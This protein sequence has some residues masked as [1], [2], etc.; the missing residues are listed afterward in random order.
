M[1]P[2][3]NGKAPTQLSA[4]FRQL[5]PNFG[6]GGKKYR[7]RTS[8]P[9]IRDCSRLIRGSTRQTKSIHI[10]AGARDNGNA[11][12]HD[13]SSP[14]TGCLPTFGT[15]WL[16]CPATFL[17]GLLFAFTGA[18]TL[19]RGSRVLSRKTKGTKIGA[20]AHNRLARL[21][22]RNRDMRRAFV[23]KLATELIRENQAVF[24]DDVE[25]Q[26]D[27]EAALGAQFWRSP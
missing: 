9:P 21:H 24:V 1:P 16:H 22:A 11:S 15:E 12:L 14:N 18:V 3:G 20:T 6:G 25:H 26:G 10:T 13:F 19:R 8:S 27:D 2:P 23:P 7:A 17:A 4:F 5:I